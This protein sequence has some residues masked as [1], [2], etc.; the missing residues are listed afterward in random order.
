ML[1]L[2]SS[3]FASHFIGGEITWEC[4]TD[5]MSPDYGKYTLFL[6]I[7]QDCD[8][9]DF[10]YFSENITVH[11]NPSLSTITCNFLD[12]NDISTS[13]VSGSSTCYNCDN[14]PF[15][16]FGAV[17]EWIYSSGPITINGT[18]PLDGWHFTW[19]TCCR[20]SNLT[21]GMNDADWTIRSVLYPYTDPSG[22]VFPNNNMC[23]DNSPIFKEQPKTLLCTGYP[24]SYSHLAFDVELDSLSYSWAEPL[25]DEFLYDPANP[26]SIALPFNAPYSVNTPI[27]GNPTLNNENGEISFLSNLSGI[28]VTCVK[29]ES[30]KCGQLVAEVFRDVN[31]ALISCGTLPNGA[32]NLPPVITAPVG[33]Q[34]W[35]TNLN[36]STNLPS[37]ETTIM[38]G[39]LVSF[40]VVAT[41]NDINI[42]GNKQ[43][44]TLEVE[45]GQLD[46]LL[47]LSNPA[48]FLTDSFAPGFVSG[49]FLWESNCDHMQDYGCG[50]Q[51][52]AYTF[53]LKAYDDFC[54][55]NG[56]VIATITIN[57]IPPQPDLRCLA[58]DANGGVDLYFYFPAGVVDTNIKY[59]IYHSKQI[60]GPYSLIDSIFYPDTNYFHLAS[61]ASNSRSYYY[62][63]G[64][65]TC[66]TNIGSASDSLLFSDTLSTILMD[67]YAINFGNTAEMNWNPIHNPLLVSSASDYD[68]HYV[69]AYNLDNIIEVLPDTFYQMDGDNCNYFPEFYVEISDIS[70]CVSR[71]SVSTVNL[72][73]TITPITPIIESVSVNNLGKSEI[74]WSSSAGADYY[75]IYVEDN[76]GVFITLDSVDAVQNSYLYEA[77]QADTII[78]RFNVRAIDSCGNSRVQSIVHNS[79]LLTY[80]SDPCDYSIELDWNE[81]LNWIGGVSHYKVLITE[82]DDNNISINT[83][84]RLDED[85]EL[86]IENIGSSSDYF[87]LIEAYNFDSTLVS[88]SNQIEINIAL[89]NKPL[90]NYIEYVTIDHNNGSVDI[91][92]L[93][94]LSAVINH[95]DVYRSIR[96]DDNFSKIGKIDFSNESP[97]Y[98]NDKDVSTNND[99]YQY[100]IYPVDTCGVSLISPIVNLPEYL[101]VMSFAQT[102]LLEAEIN[103]DSL[104]NISAYSGQYTNSLVFNNY[105][106]WLGEVSKYNLYRSFNGEP[107]N[108]IPIYTWDRVQNPDE[109]LIYVDVVTEFYEGNGNFCYY[110]E[111]IEGG[112]TPYGPA[113]EGS[114]S[115]IVCVSQVPAVFIPSVFTPNGDEHNEIFIPI[116]YFVSKEGFSFSIYN[117]DGEAI[118][119]T[120]NPK[121][122]WDGSFLGSQVQNGNYV[123]RIQFVNGDGKLS[124]KTGVITLVR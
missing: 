57:V 82:I 96:N 10:S 120:D 84:I 38:A 7:Y 18:P 118:F 116:T 115:N 45:G 30:Y 75:I 99:F 24:F 1:I 63:L 109:K 40:S 69:N 46:P 112:N 3:L 22:T 102:I 6:H 42:T 44:L 31:V 78:E 76:N 13:G 62:L 9:I 23:H 122:G 12:T 79:I 103:V 105:E 28:F 86:T 33:S 26:N 74:S 4:N 27:P 37:Y 113:I 55:A 91:S 85:T 50:R 20:S 61:N 39:E 106:K 47:A 17:K 16:T 73:D 52:G 43:N 77:S 34:N 89:A 100:Q 56:I 70:G 59:D 11:N 53:N 36:P 80:N 97:I 83:E 25:G 60:N 2:S 54:P 121:K 48:T 117:R 104:Q 14:Q 66:G 58:V 29:V 98:Y 32:Q 95:Y 71:S 67:A 101:D 15:G 108:L 65:V 49:I 5:P 68:L 93:V 123:Y 110:I 8:G 51:G 64:S 107:F 111:A 21:Q 114:R 92:C 72:L 88:R 35:T 87:V 41:D 94:D 81:Y 119:E 124:E 90:F 19:G